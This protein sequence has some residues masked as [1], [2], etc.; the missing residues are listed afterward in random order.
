MTPR[1]GNSNNSTQKKNPLSGAI[2]LEI[3]F[4]S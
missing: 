3:G 1:L 4:G 2:F